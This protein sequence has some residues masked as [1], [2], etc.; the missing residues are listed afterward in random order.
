MHFDVLTTMDQCRKG[1]FEKAF[2]TIHLP[3]DKTSRSPVLPWGRGS[4]LERC[5][6]RELPKI[7][8][9]ALL[10][11]TGWLISPHQLACGAYIV[12]WQQ[13][14]LSALESP[15]SLQSASS[16]TAYSN[17]HAHH[18]PFL[19]SA[20]LCSQHSSSCYTSTVRLAAAP[21]RLNFIFRQDGSTNVHGEGFFCGG[22]ELWRVARLD[23]FASFSR[24]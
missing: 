24:G 3:T 18:F 20:C 4:L 5:K 14:T 11:A 12:W 22:A 21:L 2:Q 17:H 6:G 23:V 1:A 7:I 15:V 13:T 10:Y 8:R 19:Q 9:R 16:T